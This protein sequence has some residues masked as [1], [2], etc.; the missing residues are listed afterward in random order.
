MRHEQRR[1][2]GNDAPVEITERFPQ[3]LGN[4][5]LENAR[6]PKPILFVSGRRERRQN[7]E[8]NHAHTQNF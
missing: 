4:L 7:N 8:I 5:S 2:Y 3:E 6:F 1:G